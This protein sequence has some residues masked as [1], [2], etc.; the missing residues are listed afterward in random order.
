MTELLKKTNITKTQEE[1]Y[2]I[3]CERLK[4][5]KIWPCVKYVSIAIKH[6]EA[7]LLAFQFN[8][9]IFKF[10]IHYFSG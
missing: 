8:R 7:F 10:S 2:K 5:R 6:G 1:I 4:G 9:D 3:Q